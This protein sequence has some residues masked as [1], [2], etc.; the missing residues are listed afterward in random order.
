MH[1]FIDGEDRMQQ[2]LLPHSLEDYVGEENPV[3]V[4]EVFIDELDLAALGFS[5][6]TPAATGR[7]AY[8]PST[9]LK[10]YLYGYLNRIQSSRRLERETQ[11]SVELMWLTGRLMPDFKTIANFRKDN[12]PAIRGACRQFIVL[13]RQLNLFSQAVV[14]VDGSKFK[15]VNNRDRNFTSAKVQRRM[16]QIEA[17]INRYLSAL[18]IADQQEATTAQ[19]KSSK[20]KEKIEALQKRM[21]QLKEIE[22]LVQATPDKQISLTDPDARSMA[23]SG[24]GTG[25]VGYNVQTVVD[26]QHHLIVAHEVT[27]VGNDRGQLASMAQQAQTAMGRKDLEVVADRGYFKGEQVLSCEGTGVAPIVLKTLTSSG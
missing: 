18:D 19:S 10:I 4:I 23:T 17:S 2:A 14:A 24:K 1:R 9:M 15:A 3:R 5:R 22:V 26:A 6:M 11:R 12:G 21:Q 8:H 27:N 7:P 13:C 16:E 20:L 25:I